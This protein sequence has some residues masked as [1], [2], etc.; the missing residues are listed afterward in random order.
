MSH[1]SCI[2]RG[3]FPLVVEVSSHE[4][5][6]AKLLWVVQDTPCRSHHQWGCPPGE[7][8]PSLDRGHRQKISRYPCPNARPVSAASHGQRGSAEVTDAIDLKN[9]TSLGYP[10]GPNLITCTLKSQGHK[11]YGKTWLQRNGK[12]ERSWFGDVRTTEGVSYRPSGAQS[13]SS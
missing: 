4:R 6:V 3:F 8:V 7:Q 5:Q 13:G 10:G 11:R 2:L 9:E 1:L 12:H